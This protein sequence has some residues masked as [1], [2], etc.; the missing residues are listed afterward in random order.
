MPRL[1]AEGVVGADAIFACLGPAL[2]VFSRY[3]RVE[4]AS[5]ERV[6]LQEYLEHVWAQVSKEALSSV[7]SGADPTGFEADA[8]VTAMWLWTLS[9]RGKGDAP[10]S[11]A[12]SDEAGEDDDA[13]DERGSGA[14]YALEFDTA[15]K[16]A[17]GL[18]AKLD[19]MPTVVEVKGNSARLLTVRERSAA[20]IG[21]DEPKTSRKKA[22]Q[23]AIGF[24]DAANDRTGAGESP[25]E[26][27]TVLDRVHQAMLLFAGAKADG[28][29]RFVVDEGV[30]QDQ[31]FW[32]LSQALAALYP[33]G[34]HERRWA[35]GVLARK[36]SLGF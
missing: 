22:G 35:E 34:S 6:S 24:N 9:A 2:E 32:R 12:D 29:K 28:V 21:R 1:A 13:S 19:T 20:L 16:I 36:K 10:D 26:G 23:L 3:A 27:S 4:K 33:P 5:G 14:G 15:R 7:F 8:R 30:G 18:G 11:S 17:Q 31:R 25:A